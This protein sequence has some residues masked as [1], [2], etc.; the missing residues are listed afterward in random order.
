MPTTE[1]PPITDVHAG[2]FIPPVPQSIEETGLNESFL[3]QLILKVLYFRGELI[4]RDLAKVLGLNYSVIDG[5]L[6]YFKLQ[7]LVA[8][9]RSLGMG[10]VS[11]VFA[12]SDQGRAL[13]TKYLDANAYAAKAP[14]PLDQYSAAV[15]LQRRRGNWLT[16]PM[17]Q[18]AFQHMVMS[19]NII[20]V[21]GPAVNSGK[22]F[23]IYGQP[24]NG[25]TYL[26]EALVKIE[27]DPIYIPYSIEA[28]GQIIQMYDPLYHQRLDVEEEQDSIWNAEP[29][30]QH[31]GR[32]FRAKR[33]FIV[34]GGELALDMLDLAFKPDSKTYDAPFQLK[35][36]NGIY[37]I[38][39][40]GRQKVSPAEVLN[41]WI[42]P[43]ER[44]IDY[45][46]FLSG[47]KM[48]IPFETF[49]VFSTNLRPEQ[50][51]D[52]AFLRRIQY[53]MFL[54]SP[55]EEEFLNIF[56][57]FCASLNL[58]IADGAIPAFVEKYYRSTG[59]M[60]RRCQPRD[61]ISHAIDL[62]NF[63]GLPYELTFETLERAFEG[64]FVADQYES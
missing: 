34:T 37:L 19:E 13:A 61:I 6:E 22:S 36:N 3:Q 24:G 53:K 21:V 7:H 63:E 18:S 58:P 27:S 39:D 49:L 1:A 42:V 10:P 15:K 35:A 51:G 62:I 4:G 38:D 55:V 9:K 54:K 5:I 25:K 57:R 31:D 28:Q 14:V 33:P 50:I 26:A 17:L 44:G 43:M 60:F 40:F 23:L 41:R 2:P 64:T 11:S 29:D 47:G 16:K 52:E 45:F 48:S 56:R 12:L 30:I 20:G 32:W 46:T 59:K 8:V